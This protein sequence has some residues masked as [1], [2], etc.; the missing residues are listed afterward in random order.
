MDGLCRMF[1]SYLVVIWVLD[2]RLGGIV[3]GCVLMLRI[4]SA[5][6]Q[7]TI[8]ISD[9]MVDDSGHVVLGGWEWDEIFKKW[10][11]SPFGVDTL[12]LAVSAYEVHATRMWWSICGGA[13]KY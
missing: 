10:G 7:C 1:R 12:G 5:V 6:M 11:R 9:H 3:S 4:L 13:D 2:F 8:D